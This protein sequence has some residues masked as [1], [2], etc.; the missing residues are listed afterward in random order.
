MLPFRNWL[1]I[2]TGSGPL[3]SKPCIARYMDVMDVSIGAPTPR[4]CPG[5]VSSA[6]STRRNNGR[7]VLLQI[8]LTDRCRSGL[9]PSQLRAPARRVHAPARHGSRSKAQKAGVANHVVVYGL[10]AAA[11]EV[12]LVPEARAARIAQELSPPAAVG[13]GARPG[14]ERI[15]I[16]PVLAHSEVGREQRE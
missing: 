4:R 13:L 1:S 14:F 2:S 7:R 10:H 12:G 16:A 6:R 3:Y 11:L 8:L 15:E 5:R 9:G